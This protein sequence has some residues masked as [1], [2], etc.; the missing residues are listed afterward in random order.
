MESSSVKKSGAERG[1]A[2]KHRCSWVNEKNPAY[3]PYHDCEWGRPHYDDA[4]FF[5]LLV[6]ESFQAGLSWECILNKR[7]AFRE[8][9]DGFDYRRIAAY[10][11]EKQAALAGNKAI[12]RNRRK[13]R[14]AVKNAAVFMRVQEEYGS[15]SAYIWHFTEGKQ[16]INRDGILRA[17]SE[18]SDRISEDLKKRGMS[19]VGSTIIYSYLQAVGV[20]DDHEPGCFLS[21]REEYEWDSLSGAPLPNR[22]NEYEEDSQSGAPLPNRTNEYEEASQSGAPL[23]NHTKAYEE[24][25]HSCEPEIHALRAVYFC[26]SD[27]WRDGAEQLAAALRA[28]GIFVNFL[29]GASLPAGE[30]QEKEYLVITDHR[31]LAALLEKHQVA[32][33]GC[34]GSEEGYF[35]G[36]GMVTDAP[37]QLSVTELEAYLF[38]CNGW[39]VTVARTR[40]LILREITQEDAPQLQRISRQEGMQ[41]LHPCEAKSGG[42]EDGALSAKSGRQEDGASMAK[43]CRQENGAPVSGTASDFFSRERLGAYIRQAYRLQGYGLWSVFTKDGTL[44]GCCGL[45]D[46]PNEAGETRP[47]SSAESGLVRLE[48]QYMLDEAYRHQGYGEEMCCAALA[49]AWTHTEHRAVWARIHPENEASI[50]LAKKLGFCRVSGELWR[51]RI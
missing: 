43:S 22:T 40:R 35:E 19:F 27:K 12:V 9:F 33:V 48:L 32:C 5:E 6:L 3:V 23:P 13:I 16:V 44:I 15:F 14:A 30:I 18:L 34:A 7:E 45:S 2:G 37:E 36:V 11:E 17:T 38:H 24:E 29:D 21:T 26:V 46:V 49:Y 10:S 41:Y 50:R 51:C 42:R 31:A 39:P 8:A 47:E 20:I 25:C 4:Y 28:S 1:S